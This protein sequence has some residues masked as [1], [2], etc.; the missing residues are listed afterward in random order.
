MSQPN[1]GLL[2]CAHHKSWQHFY[3]TIQQFMSQRSF[4]DNCNI[5][6]MMI[7]LQMSTY[8]LQDQPSFNNNCNIRQHFEL[9]N[10][11]IYDPTEF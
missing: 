1:W 7:S 5:Q 6:I 2:I 11:V 4:N 10:R 9:T 8:F 3:E